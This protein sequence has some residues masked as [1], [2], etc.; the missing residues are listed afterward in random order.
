M[1]R[2]LTDY[3]QTMKPVIEISGRD[4]IT[5]EFDNLATNT[6]VDIS[7]PHHK[8]HE[9]DTF[10]ASYKSPDASPIADNANLD[11]LVVVGATRA[12]FTFEAACGGDAEVLL[13]EGATAS[14]NGARNADANM[15]RNEIGSGP[16][17]ATYNTPTVTGAG[18]QLANLFLP[19]GTRNQAT[20]GTIRAGTEWVLRTNTTYLL[21]LTNRAGSAQPASLA[22]QWYEK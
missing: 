21:R 18:N 9:G 11:I 16:T 5:A 4:G 17:T 7:Y 10:E 22:V 3:E 6:K 20:G 15:N 13:Y 19:G 2:S 12:H 14:S 1:P 8:V